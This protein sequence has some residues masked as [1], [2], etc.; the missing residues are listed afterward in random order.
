MTILTKKNLQDILNLIGNQLNVL[1]R[2][3]EYKDK[4]G[5]AYAKYW[6][7]EVDVLLDLQDKIC[8]LLKDCK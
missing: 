1:E 3:E 8:A 2:E 5:P 4:H 6:Q 7:K